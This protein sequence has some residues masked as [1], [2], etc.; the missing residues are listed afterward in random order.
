MSAA[1]SDTSATMSAP[2]SPA[3]TISTRFPRDLG[4]AP[5]LGTVQDLPRERLLTCEVRLVGMLMQA[6]AHGDRVELL[7]ASAAVG[8]DGDNAPSASGRLRGDRFNARPEPDVPVDPERVAVALEIV[9]VL[10]RRH[11]LDPVRGDRKVRERSQEARR[12]E[13]D[14]LPHDAGLFVEAEDSAQA[15]GPLETHRVMAFLEQLL[16]RGQTRGPGADDGYALWHLP[17]P[18]T[19][20]NPGLT[21]CT[22][23]TTRR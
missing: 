8:V 7:L 12:R 1:C 4:G 18:N 2:D 23:A 19:A 22:L 6:A 3:P 13:P 5:V 11:L 20:A 15:A 17:L 21:A 9:D 14:R 16:H 10:P